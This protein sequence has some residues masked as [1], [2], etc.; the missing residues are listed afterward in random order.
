MKEGIKKHTF[1]LGTI[2]LF[3][4]H[5]L[6]KL[7]RLKNRFA[8]GVT[9]SGDEI[10]EIFELLK[11]FAEEHPEVN[12]RV[13]LSKSGE[14]VLSWYRLL[15]ELKS[16]FKKVR[17]ESS[18]N[19]PFLAGELQSGK[20]DFLLVAPTTSNSTAKIALGI[21]D[22]MITNAVNMAVKARIPVYVY[23]CEAGEEEKETVLPSG[24]KL[25]LIIRDLDAKY[26]NTLERA[27]GIQIIHSLDNIKVVLEKHY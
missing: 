15:D 11:S 17:I 25:K 14:Q 22:T 6:T 5:A 23:P 4:F 26:I 12:V 13:Y 2:I 21:G 10:R 16:S 20:Y 9:G 19:V 1:T 24:K 27:P 18:S 3:L 7:M 8:W